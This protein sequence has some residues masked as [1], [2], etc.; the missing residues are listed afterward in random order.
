MRGRVQRYDVMV[1]CC[2]LV[3]A[4]LALAACAA[5][6]FSL[7]SQPEQELL[8]PKPPLPP[9]IQWVRTIVGPEDAGIRKG[10]WTKA[11]EFFTGADANSIVRPYG[12]LLDR[13]DRLIIADPGAGVVHLMDAKLN[14]YVVIGGDAEKKMRTPIG[15]TEDLQNHL[16]ITDSTSGE[17]YR[18]EIDTGALRPFAVPMLQRPTGIAYNA[19]NKRLYIV[20]TLSNE[21]VAV[22]ENGV[23]KARFGAQFNHPTD[24]CV[25]GK[26]QVYVTDP[27]TYS[28]KVFTPEGQLVAKIGA[29]GD[30][31]GN[32][33]KPKGVAVDR[34]GHIYINDA[35]LDAVQVFDGSGQYLLSFGSTGK[36]RGEFWMPSG[37]YID[38]QDYILVADTYNRR[39]QIFRYLPAEPPARPEAA[40]PKAGAN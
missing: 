19:V 9:R 6:P 22:D 29:A 4:L 11:L 2:L 8:W 15:L 1:R 18:Y 27:L 7:R 20:D 35:L 32:L 5:P 38:P 17:V 26:G 25:D 39:V 13:A 24:I 12:V 21:V 36:G 40:T 34:D 23:E 28:I 37:I 16:F 10:F 14:R 31:L 30:Q 3:V 33:N